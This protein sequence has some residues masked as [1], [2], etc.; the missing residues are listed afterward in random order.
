MSISVGLQLFQQF[1]FKNFSLGNFI[2]SFIAI[3]LF[4]N[5]LIH[6][7]YLYSKYSP[8]LWKNNELFL[9]RVN[10]SGIYGIYISLVLIL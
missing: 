2:F 8:L 10:F 6:E 9:F 7:L 5:S 1:V 4:F 3:P